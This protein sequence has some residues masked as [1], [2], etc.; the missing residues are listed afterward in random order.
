MPKGLRAQLHEGFAEWLE[1][2]RD[3]SFFEVDEI[4]G[5]HLERA[6]LLRQELGERNEE[7]ARRTARRLLAAGHG[8]SGRADLPAAT[9]LFQRA[10][11]VDSDDELTQLQATFE[12]ARALTVRGELERADSYLLE[13]IE[14]A[15]EVGDRG[16]LARARLAHNSLLHRV[17]SDVTVEE[18]LAQALDILASLEGTDELEALVTAYTEVGMCKFMLGRAGEGELDLERAAAMA[19]ALGDTALLRGTMG[20]RLRPLGWGPTR[21]ADGA[22]LC[23][24]LLRPTTRTP[25]SGSRRSRFSPCCARCSETSRDLVAP[26]RTRGR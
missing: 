6:L 14:Q 22:A 12:L 25:R 21:A 23:E 9:G 13:A 2:A 4:V 19:A 8:A 24:E 7:L 16:I 26:P 17:S 20:A 15:E 3:E 1:H 10:V 11:D 5:Y 18:E